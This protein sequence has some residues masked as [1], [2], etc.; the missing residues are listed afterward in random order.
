MRF[1]KAQNAIP[2]KWMA[3]YSVTKMTTTIIFR[4]PDIRA[5]IFFSNALQGF[6]AEYS[7]KEKFEHE[8]EQQL[9]PSARGGVLCLS[10]VALYRRDYDIHDSAQGRWGTKAIIPE[11]TPGQPKLS[12]ELGWWIYPKA[13][14][15]ARQC[16]FYCT[17]SV[18]S[19]RLYFSL[20][21][22]LKSAMRCQRSKSA[23]FMN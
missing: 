10:G 23:S 15:H 11:Q 5:G 9:R 1:L 2:A 22:L 21:S 20:S 16:P 7:S 3:K 13:D 6:G 18:A 17:S 14:N 4:M 19:G 12:G 8:G